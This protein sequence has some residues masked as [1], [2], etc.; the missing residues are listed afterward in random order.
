[1]SEEEIT[2]RLKPEWSYLVDAIEVNDAPLRKKIS[3]SPQQRKDLA[4]RMDVISLDKLEADIR[5]RRTDNKFMIH[6]TG[7][8]R[9]QVTQECV[10]TGAP[11]VS[12]LEGSLEG[13]FAES[14]KAVSLTK[15]RHEKMSQMM[16]AEVPVLSDE[17]DPDLIEEGTFDLGELVV[18][19]AILEINPYPRAENAEHPDVIKEDD[20]NKQE[21]KINNPFAALKNWKEKQENGKS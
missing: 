5:V 21:K 10:V 18:Q 6:A 13:W 16:N 3:A 14:D 15:K 11:V 8:F 1:M 19:H 7:S 4:R 9:G 2:Q 20:L 17:D 12:V